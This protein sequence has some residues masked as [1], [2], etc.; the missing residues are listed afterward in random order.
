[1][2]AAVGAPV[3]FFNMDAWDGY[4]AARDRFLGLLGECSVRNPV[5]LTGDI[6]SAWQGDL[7]ANFDDASSPILATEFVG[8]SVTSVFPPEY[9]PLVQATLP[10]NP[11]IGYF[12]GARRG[13]MLHEVTRHAWRAE[14]MGVRD[15]TDVNSPVD[16]LAAFKIL[17]GK[18]GGLP[19]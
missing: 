13:Y 18:P 12:D 11:H 1:L 5:V 14:Y 3:P 9:I 15:V 8:T 6:H 16:V 2:R 4:S 17:E 7:R 19:E 10:S